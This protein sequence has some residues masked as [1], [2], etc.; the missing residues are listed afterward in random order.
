MGYAPKHPLPASLN[1]VFMS[2]ESSATIQKI[3]KKALI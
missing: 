3:I 1:P 2:Q